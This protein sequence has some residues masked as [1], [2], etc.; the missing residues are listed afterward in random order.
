MRGYKIASLSQCR[1]DYAKLRRGHKGPVLIF[2][3]HLTFIDSIVLIW[4]LSSGFKYWF[5]F[6]LMPWNL[7]KAVHVKGSKLYQLVCYL[8]KCR[9]IY[10][11]KHK[12]VQTMISA[13]HLLDNNQTLMVFPE[14]TR[15]NTGRINTTTYVYGVGQLV[16]DTPKALVLSVY[17][18]GRKQKACSLMP[19]K[20]DIFDVSIKVISP[21]TTNRGLR[22]K[23]EIASQ[24]IDSLVV[25]EEGYYDNHH[26]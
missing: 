7:P 11:D 16:I 15:S 12:N 22:A 2:P 19:A 23:R 21:K 3:N 6:R 4:A 9:L 5:S 24:L 18:R 1:A 10:Q 13:Q 25:M 14:G 17:L 20:G 26:W 8:G